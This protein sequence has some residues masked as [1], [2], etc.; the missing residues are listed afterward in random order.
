[1]DIFEL[2]SCLFRGP[3]SKMKFLKDRGFGIGA[4]EPDDFQVYGKSAYFLSNSQ[5][6][7][8]MSDICKLNSS[9]LNVFTSDYHRCSFC[10]SDEWISSVFE[11]LRACA[12][13]IFSRKAFDC[14][15][16]K[17]ESFDSFW[18]DIPKPSNELEL[19]AFAY[20]RRGRQ[21]QYVNIYDCNLNEVT[22]STDVLV[23]SMVKIC[24]RWVF[25]VQDSPDGI[26][27][28]F[29]PNISSGVV[30]HELN[31][32]CPS[33]RSP[34]NWSDIDFE[35][36]KIPMY[37]RFNVKCPALTVV[38]EFGGTFK[39]DLSGNDV[40]SRALSDFHKRAS[41]L[42]WDGTIHLRT[43]KSVRVGD[44]VLVTVFCDRNKDHINWYTDKL[45]HLEIAA[46]QNSGIPPSKVDKKR[47][48]DSMDSSV[49]SK[50]KRQCTLRESGGHKTD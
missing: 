15:S 47:D 3:C 6:L 7:K 34:W 17:Y 13:L 38:S 16:E 49:A 14:I 29:R 36:L 37:S 33:I 48:A 43:S 10:A 32:I 20:S 39:V 1:M 31:G 35:T 50:T 22:G 44:R 46:V 5:E 27:F 19:S 24:L 26:R 40:F 42:E 9:S 2:K 21:K 41:A 23:G 28:G 30:V 12:Y 11:Q 45:F 8:T 25:Y 4:Q 18:N